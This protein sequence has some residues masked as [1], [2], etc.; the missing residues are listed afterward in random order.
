MSFNA[1]AATGQNT[2]VT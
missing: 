2:L 1:N